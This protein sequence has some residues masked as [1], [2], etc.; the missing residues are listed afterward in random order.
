MTS[1]SSEKV[2]FVSI[3]DISSRSIP[4][5]IGGKAVKIISIEA[6]ASAIFESV[7][8]SISVVITLLSDLLIYF[9]LFL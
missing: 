8:L 9:F 5:R 3:V 4:A 2:S 6:W 1:C 7:P